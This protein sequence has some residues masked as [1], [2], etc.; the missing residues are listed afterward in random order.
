MVRDADA[1]RKSPV[2]F[3]GSKYYEEITGSMTKCREAASIGDYRGWVTLLNQ[4]YNWTVGFLQDPELKTELVG[5]QREVYGL[6]NKL[7]IRFFRNNVS[8][9][10]YELKMKIDAAECKLFQA[11]AD[12]EMLVKS[13]GDDITDWDP[14][15][16]RKEIFG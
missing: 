2:L 15:Q 12:A 13:G 5:L 16:L 3:A 8:R 9:M 11:L 14:E 4:L 10:E 7:Q 1:P 6:E